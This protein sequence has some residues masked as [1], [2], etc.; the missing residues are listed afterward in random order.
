MSVSDRA[1]QDFYFQAT[2]SVSGAFV[3]YLLS[4]NMIKNVSPLS[5]V[6]VNVSGVSGRSGTRP[7]AQKHIKQIPE[8]YLTHFASLSSY[9]R[10]VS[11][12]AR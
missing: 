3:R 2:R 11:S 7:T 9:S 12:G 8:W 10:L 5:A 6:S 4:F 1:I